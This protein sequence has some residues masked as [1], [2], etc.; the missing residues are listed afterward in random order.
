MNVFNKNDFGK[1][2]PKR[3]FNEDSGDTNILIVM[4]SIIKLVG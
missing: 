2:C 4:Y 3:R 1:N